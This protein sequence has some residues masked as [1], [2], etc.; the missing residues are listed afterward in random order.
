M[1]E[2]AAVRA[3]THVLAFAAFEVCIWKIPHAAGNR[4]EAL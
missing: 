3:K 2:A 4:K 1:K